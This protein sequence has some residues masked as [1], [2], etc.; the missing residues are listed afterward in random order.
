MCNRAKQLRIL[1]ERRAQTLLCVGEGRGEGF[2]ISTQWRNRFS[3]KLKKKL[4]NYVVKQ[5]MEKI[6]KNVKNY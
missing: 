4:F 5:Y 3:G 6:K 2:S 1:R